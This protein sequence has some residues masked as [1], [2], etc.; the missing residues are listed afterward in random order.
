M[1]A[2]PTEN[3]EM[4]TTAID[5]AGSS[6]G[7]LSSYYGIY[8]EGFTT[9]SFKLGKCRRKQLR[10]SLNLQMSSVPVGSQLPDIS[11]SNTLSEAVVIHAG[12]F[13]TGEEKKRDL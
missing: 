11:M 9:V 12:T 10:K 4:L 13:V 3:T 2:R 1:A 5:A 7:V 8:A 6:Y